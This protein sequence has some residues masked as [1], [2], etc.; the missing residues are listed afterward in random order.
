[1]ASKEAN[2]VKY[3]DNK[4]YVERYWER[5]A[6]T[7]NGTITTESEKTVTKESEKTVTVK[8]AELMNFILPDLSVIEVTVSRNGQSDEQY[9]KALETANRT[10]NSENRRLQSL[11]GKYQ[12]IIRTGLNSIMFDIKNCK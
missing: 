8:E 12:D 4:K 7:S 1:M 5:K 10:I 6:Q 9:I 11:L 3:Q 2:K